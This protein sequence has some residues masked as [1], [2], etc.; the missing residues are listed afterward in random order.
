MK[1]GIST[2]SL[3]PMKME[4]ALLHLGEQGISLCECFFN[5]PSELKSDSLRRIRRIAEENSIEI[6]SLHPFTTEMESFFF[7]TD[8]PGRL[9]DGLELYRRYFDAAA[10]LGA[11]Y[12]VF[13]GEYSWNHFEWDKGLAQLQRLWEEGQRFGI[14]LL[15]ENVARCKGGQAAY[16]K[17]LQQ[18]LPQLGF[19]LDC[20]QAL[21]AGQKPMDFVQALGMGIRHIHF[22][23]ATEQQDCLPPGKG[24]ADL[25]A[26][27]AAFHQQGAEP[28]LVIELYSDSYESLEEVVESRNYTQNLIKSVKNNYNII[29]NVNKNKKSF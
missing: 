11:K 12:L 23:D 2:A 29:Q 18:A 13:H 6:V 17:E 19:V 5:T 3:F 24:T 25:P 4:E 22:S 15:H 27:L 1:C 20:K 14:E 7:F 16:L 10:Y 9:E 28:S 21:R 26:L 8:Y